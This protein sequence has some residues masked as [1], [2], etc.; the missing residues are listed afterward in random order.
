ML[1]K[2]LIV[3][4][5][6]FL[7]L[8]NYSSAQSESMYLPIV[9]ACETQSGTLIDEAQT[10]WGEMPFFQAQGVIRDLNGEWYDTT[11]ISTVNPVTQTYSIIILDSS[12]AECLLMVGRGFRPAGDMMGTSQSK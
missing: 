12:G 6:I 4:L 5:G 9:L 11:V 10:E 1:G 3:S 7:M 2:L 8:P